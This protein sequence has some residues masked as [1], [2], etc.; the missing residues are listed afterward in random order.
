MPAPAADMASAVLNGNLLVAGGIGL[1]TGSTLAT[2]RVYSPGTDR[3][4]TKAPLPTPRA[5]AAG[6]EAGG[7]FFVMGG[8][9]NDEITSKVTAYT[10]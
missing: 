7:L 10:P 9:E 4:T 5:Y 2:L 8:F 1:N 6:A 3:W